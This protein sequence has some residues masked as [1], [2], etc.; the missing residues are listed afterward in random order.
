MS[1]PLEAGTINQQQ[2]PSPYTAIRSQ[3]PAIQG[4]PISWLSRM[5]L[6]QH[7]RHMRMMVLYGQHGDRALTGHLGNRCRG[8]NVAVKIVRDQCRRDLK[9]F[10]QVLDGLAESGE[11]LRIRQLPDM[12]RDKGLVASRDTHRVLDR[13]PT[14]KTGGPI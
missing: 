4:Q 6:G 5:M 14:A 2:L 1:R 8:K 3:R 13:P 11:R 9:H 12:L 10:E 7:C